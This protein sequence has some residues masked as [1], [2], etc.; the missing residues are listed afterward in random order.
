[1]S[2]KSIADEIRR[3]PWSG[4]VASWEGCGGT[5]REASVS[6]GVATVGPVSR[7]LPLMGGDATAVVGTGG[8][9]GRRRRG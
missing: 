7:Y 4:H 9:R 5:R 3:P 8:G 1:M 6:L 2:G